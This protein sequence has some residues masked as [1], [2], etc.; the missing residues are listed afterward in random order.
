MP[1]KCH[2]SPPHRGTPRQM[3]STPEMMKAHPHSAS[4][5][6]CPL[7]TPPLH[8][9]LHHTAHRD[10]N[11]RAPCNATPASAHKRNRADT[12]EHRTHNR[13]PTPHPDGIN[14][15]GKRSLAHIQ[16]QNP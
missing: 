1:P 6:H 12:T 4:S 9:A 10:S 11:A 5:T 15:P 16:H 13:P 8:P 7:Q 2:E 3:S 14:S